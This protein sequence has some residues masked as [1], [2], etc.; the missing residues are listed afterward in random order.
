MHDVGRASG[1]CHDVC[2]FSTLQGFCHFDVGGMY[3]VAL[4]GKFA[5]RN[6]VDA[7]FAHKSDYITP[8]YA[9]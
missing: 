3:A 1:V 9:S 2:V 6:H 8:C 7:N 5:F 4:N